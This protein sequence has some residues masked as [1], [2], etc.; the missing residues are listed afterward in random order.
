MKSAFELAQSD[1]REP[2]VLSTVLFV[3][4]PSCRTE[5]LIVAVNFNNEII[6]IPRSDSPVHVSSCSDLP[7]GIFIHDLFARA[8]VQILPFCT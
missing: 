5:S 7:K 6:F 8:V 2:E 4:C 1:T 3:S